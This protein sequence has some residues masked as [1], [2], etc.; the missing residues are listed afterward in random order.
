MPLMTSDIARLSYRTVDVFGLTIAAVLFAWISS[1]AYQHEA[2]LAFGNSL[3]NLRRTHTPAPFELVISNI[4]A[5]TMNKLDGRNAPAVREAEGRAYIRIYQKDEK[6]AYEGYPRAAPTRSNPREIFL[7]P[8]CRYSREKVDAVT[9]PFVQKIEGPG[10][11]IR[12]NDIP[13]FEVIDRKE[14]PCAK[15]FD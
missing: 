12:V 3:M 9:Q 6:F 13:A 5:R 10:V 1:Y 11:F 15:L 4:S 8:A 2:V 7:S 14:S